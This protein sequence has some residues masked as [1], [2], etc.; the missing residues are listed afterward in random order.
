MSFNT[1]D[2]GQKLRVFYCD[3]IGLTGIMIVGICQDLM[4]LE[5]L[6][7]QLLLN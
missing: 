3:E 6:K 5:K 7:F 1:E 2:P 4:Q